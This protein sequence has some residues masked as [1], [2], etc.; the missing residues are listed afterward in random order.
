[1]LQ[2]TVLRTSGRGYVPHGEGQEAHDGEWGS[3]G[4]VKAGWGRCPG[5]SKGGLCGPKVHA[6]GRTQRV[7]RRG[8]GQGRCVREEGNKLEGAA[9]GRERGRWVGGGAGG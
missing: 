7:R 4:L 9:N 3:S 1:M 6:G 5:R 2:T 8:R